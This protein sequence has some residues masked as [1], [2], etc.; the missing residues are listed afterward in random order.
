MLNSS[1]QA[2]KQPNTLANVSGRL[3]NRLLILILLP[4][5]LAVLLFTYETFKYSEKIAQ[6]TFDKSLSILSV[7]LMEQA[8]AYNGDALS[9]EILESITNSLGHVFFYQ[10]RTTDAILLAGYSNAPIPSKEIIQMAAG[11]PQ[12]FI[13]EYRNKPVRAA[14]LRNF[15]SSPSYSGWVEITVWQ[16]FDAQQKMQSSL[17]ARSL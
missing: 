2:L 9:E 5:L 12:L 3:R 15:R 16:F 1:S 13:G 14:H 10:L 8:D 6:Q 11:R 7:T 4:L 17:F